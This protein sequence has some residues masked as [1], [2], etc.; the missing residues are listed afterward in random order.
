MPR[1]KK[2]SNY[3]EALEKLREDNAD[4]LKEVFK[5]M[6]DITQNPEAE[7][8]DRV[9][10]SKVVVSL[11][12]VARPAPEKTD[13]KSLEKSIE[14]PTLSKEHQSVLDEILKTV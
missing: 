2:P 7:D 6:Y 4:K 1:R 3:K 14:K 10:A 11:L 5:T 12:G 13:G 9:N 8:K